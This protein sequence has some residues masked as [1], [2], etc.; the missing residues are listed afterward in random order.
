[1]EDCFKCTLTKRRIGYS[2]FGRHKYFAAVGLKDTT[3][4]DTLCAENDPIIL[5]KMEF[6]IQL[7]K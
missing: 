5:E 1:M 4:G 2:V 7:Y 6:L 3:T